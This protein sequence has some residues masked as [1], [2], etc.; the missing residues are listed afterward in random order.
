MR[1]FGRVFKGRSIGFQS[2]HEKKV[3]KKIRK[4]SSFLMLVRHEV[5]EENRAAP[6]QYRQV[7]RDSLR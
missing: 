6:R 1:S 5:H 2:W 3:K 7:W 4:N